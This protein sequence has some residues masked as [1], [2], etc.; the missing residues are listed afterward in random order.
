MVGVGHGY[1]HTSIE[2]SVVVM[3]ASSDST[4]S[5]PPMGPM[6]C[7]PRNTGPV[8]ARPSSAIATETVGSPLHETVHD[9]DAGVPRGRQSPLDVGQSL[10]ASFVREGGGRGDFSEVDSHTEAGVTAG[11][12]S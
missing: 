4:F 8:E 9:F 12:T 7:Q 2:L 3:V 10:S 1:F 5:V 11:G 6:P